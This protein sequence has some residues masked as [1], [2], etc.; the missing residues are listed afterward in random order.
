MK[1]GAIFQF[2]SLIIIIAGII[3]FIQKARGGATYHIRKIAGLEAIEEAIGRATEMGRMVHFSPGITGLTDTRSA[4]TFAGIETLG[5]VARLVARY[6]AKIFVSLCT[7]LVFPIAQE[8]VKTAYMAE[9]KVEAFDDT[10]V[11]YLASHQFAYAAS[12]MSILQ[13]EKAAASIM[14]GSFFAES[15]MMAEAGFHAGAIQIAG[16]ANISQ[17]PFFVAACDYV[18]IG[19][20]IFAAGAIASGNPIKLGSIIGQDFGKVYAVAIILIGAL[21][22]TFGVDAFTNLITK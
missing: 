11:Q 18:L 21:L 13:R 1:T 6:G 7:V 12:I 8:V 2:I 17:I 10:S 22:S 15:L 9:G 5:Y 14:I 4:Q 19:E 16:T 3:Y 20:E